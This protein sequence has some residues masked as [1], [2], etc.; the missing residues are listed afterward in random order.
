MT[1]NDISLEQE[2][3]NQLGFYPSYIEVLEDVPDVA[4]LVWAE[5]ERVLTEPWAPERGMWLGHAVSATIEDYL[6]DS[7]ANRLERVTFNDPELQHTI[8]FFSFVLLRLG[9]GIAAVRYALD[10]E[11]LR[12]KHRERAPDDIPLTSKTPR[13]WTV[14]ATA[15]PPLD[16]Q[17]TLIHSES[18]HPYVDTTFRYL[19]D[20]FGTPNV[21]SIYRAF[22]VDP[23]FLVAVVDT[24]SAVQTENSELRAALQGLYAKALDI[25]EGEKTAIASNVAEADRTTAANLL[26]DFHDNLSTLLLTLY[27][28]TQFVTVHR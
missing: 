22:A 9:I 3:R 14:G 13:Y 21:N 2:V 15:N 12:Q 16:P 10:G 18:A 28:G 27:L 20:T 17:L 19:M 23:A 11:T 26:G 7:V 25:D 24:Q 5:T 8:D 1:T 4:A 6:P